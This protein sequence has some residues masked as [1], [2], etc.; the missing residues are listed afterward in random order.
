MDT[1][2]IQAVLGIT[3][4]NN[5]LLLEALTHRSYPNENREWII[6]NNERLDMLGR[7]VVDLIATNYL[8][9]E[10]LDT[11]K[12][13]I[14]PV[15]GALV[16]TSALATIG[17]D[18]NL[19]THLLMSRGQR[20]DG[21]RAMDLL[22]ANA[23]MAIIGA[24]YSDQGYDVAA[25]FCETHILYK[26]ARILRER[27]YQDNKS[28]FQAFSQENYKITPI[29]RVTS[30]TGSDHGKVFT[31]GLFVEDRLIA[32]GSGQSK[33]EAEQAA[34]GKA[35]KEVGLTISAPA[36]ITNCPIL[37]VG[38]S[39]GQDSNADAA[40]IPFLVSELHA[41]CERL[42]GII[43]VVYEHASETDFGIFC[44]YYGFDHS[45]HVRDLEEV[46]DLFSVSSNAVYD[47]L[48]TVW[49]QLS[50]KADSDHEDLKKECVRLHKIQ[51]EASM[52]VTAK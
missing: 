27:L 51:R 41:I 52:S 29:Y 28:R 2:E 45:L 35:V 21:P 46:A 47:A 34:A 24:L 42:N 13:K 22:V 30:E 49:R 12:G 33:S 18:L 44:H 32:E 9:A 48:S 7:S 37:R 23:L 6:P 10:F 38:E 3:F 26:A 4:G 43:R 15:R 5:D 16:K 14:I 40:R 19:G 36:E 50:S 1:E 8:L 39:T 20:D 17:H 25:K 31:V 11:P